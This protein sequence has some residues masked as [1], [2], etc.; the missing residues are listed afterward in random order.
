MINKIKLKFIALYVL[1][2]VLYCTIIVL[3]MVGGAELLGTPAGAL[4]GGIAGGIIGY[5]I[6]AQLAEV[7]LRPLLEEVLR[8]EE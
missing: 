8:E 1:L 3:G 2:Q 4:G 5:Y 6:L 7:Y